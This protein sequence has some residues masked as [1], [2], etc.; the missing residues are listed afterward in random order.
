MLLD[1]NLNDLLPKSNLGFISASLQKRERLSKFQLGAKN[2]FFGKTHT[3]ETKEK[4]RL[5]QSGRKHTLEHRLKVSKNHAKCNS[6]IVLDLNSG[7]FYESAKEVSKIFN[8][9]HSTLRSRLNGKLKNKTNFIY[10]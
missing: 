8:I 6:K 2:H 5:A 3:L 7:I 10:C 9:P 4:L 1:F